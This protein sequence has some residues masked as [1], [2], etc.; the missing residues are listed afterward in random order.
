[1]MFVGGS[2]VGVGVALGLA[3]GGVGREGVGTPCVVLTEML[4]LDEPANTA[5]TMPTNMTSPDATTNTT[6]RA[7]CGAVWVGDRLGRITGGWSSR[8]SVPQYLHRTTPVWAGSGAPHSVHWGG[9]LA[10]TRSVS[11]RSPSFRRIHSG[12]IPA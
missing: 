3:P 12:F 7:F 5:A 11:Q 1:M 4:L 2:G 8:C 6:T 10:M 9:G